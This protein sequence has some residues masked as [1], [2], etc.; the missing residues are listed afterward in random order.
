[1]DPKCVERKENKCL[2]LSNLE[3]RALPPLPND[4]EE[5]ICENTPIETMPTHLPPTLTRLYLRGTK[6]GLLPQLPE[7]LLYVDVA[8]T[9]ISVLPDLPKSLLRLNC[10]LTNLTRLPSL[11]EGMLWLWCSETPIRELPMLPNSLETLVCSPETN[12]VPS[13][14]STRILLERCVV[15]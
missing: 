7:G 3:M 8:D 12:V 1:M 2:V 11:P 10:F 4:L 13:N 9:P 5:L 15:R 6:V 14:Q